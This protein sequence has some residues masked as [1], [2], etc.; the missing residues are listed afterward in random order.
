MAI[1]ITAIH[2]SGGSGHEHIT[3]LWWTGPADG[4]TGDNTRAELVAW[5][6]N[7]NGKAYVEDAYR[8]RIDVEVITP[9]VGA[10]YLRTRKDG[11]LTDNLL[12]LPKK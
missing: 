6:E 2:L 4:K 1:R 11:V 7:E 12:Y 3:R 8:H 5:I 9:R 10:K